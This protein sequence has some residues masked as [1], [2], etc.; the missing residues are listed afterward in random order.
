MWCTGDALHA[1]CCAV[2]RKAAKA[3]PPN[4]LYEILCVFQEFSVAA[5]LLPT[6][7][8]PPALERRESMR[9]SASASFEGALDS[10][11]HRPLLRGEAHPFVGHNTLYCP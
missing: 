4:Y 10:A 8:L 2:L 6:R 7:R 9:A 11:S 1:V 3:S 5:E